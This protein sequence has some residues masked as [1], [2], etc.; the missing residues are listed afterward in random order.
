MIMKMQG[1]SALPVSCKP[2]EVLWR[3][4]YSR[5]VVIRKVPKTWRNKIH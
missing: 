5:K 1:F 3:R 2:C 4:N